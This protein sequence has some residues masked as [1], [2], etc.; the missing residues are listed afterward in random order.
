VALVLVLTL[1]AL[2]TVLVAFALTVSDQDRGEA[3]KQVKNTVMV[4]V[5]ESALQYAKVFFFQRYNYWNTYLALDYTGLPTTLPA[6]FEDMLVPNL[7]TGFRCAIFARDDADE[8]TTAPN[9]NRDN[10]NRIYVGAV[11]RGPSG[12]ISEL[13]APLECTGGCSGSSYSSQNAGGTMGLNNAS[14]VTGA[15]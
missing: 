12:K 2:L 1:V 6:G 8:L 9:P 10:N 5:A 13:L 4:E 15:R 14:R 3:G 7:P 11:C